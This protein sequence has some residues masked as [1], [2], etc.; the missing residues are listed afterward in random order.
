MDWSII[1]KNWTLFLDR[2][3]VLNIEK[4]QDYIYHAEEFRFYPGVPEAMAI[5]RKKFGRIV[6]VTN[7]RGIEK[8]LMTVQNLNDIHQHMQSVLSEA[9]GAVDKIY[10][11]SSLLD[12]HPGRKPQIGMALEAKQDFPEINFNQS[13]MVGNNLSDMYFGRNAGMVTVF[14]LTTQPDLPLPHPAVDAAYNNLLN[15]AEAL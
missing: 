15:F 10:F 9:G 2:D 13:V 14:M 12:D 1:D 5:L 11:N 4:Y 7:Q 3:G 8:G 6:L